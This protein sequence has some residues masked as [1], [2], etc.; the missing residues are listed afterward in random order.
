[1]LA[2]VLSK[3]LEVWLLQQF[4]ALAMWARGNNHKALALL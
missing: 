3:G 2:I 1:M 4:P